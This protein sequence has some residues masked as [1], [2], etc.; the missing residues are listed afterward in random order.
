MKIIVDKSDMIL[1]MQNLPRK[2]W[3][4]TDT[5]CFDLFWLR[6]PRALTPSP[7]QGCE[8][9]S[10]RYSRSFN[11]RYIGRLEHLGHCGT[12]TRGIFLLAC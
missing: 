6:S 8:G 4:C 5:A 7:L 1:D 10:P 2:P 11:K 9:D 12:P 3:T